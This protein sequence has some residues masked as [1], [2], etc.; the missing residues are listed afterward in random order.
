M[1]VKRVWIIEGC[2]SCNLCEDVCS[3]IFEVPAGGESK[4]R[5]GWEQHLSTPA[6]QP[7][8]QEAVDSC[9]VEVI[10]IEKDE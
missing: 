6:M 7:K 4:L 8:I 10:K 1:Q 9:P 2:I 3:E 5:K